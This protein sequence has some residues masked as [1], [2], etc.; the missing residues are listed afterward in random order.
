MDTITTAH[1]LVFDKDKVLLVR[2]GESAG[3]LTGVYGIP[4]GHLQEG[5]SLKEAAIREFHEETGLT[6]DESDVE[7]FPRNTY[8][9]D[10]QRKDGS[11]KHYAMTIFAGVM[12]VGELKA[13]GET[14]PEWIEVDK[15]SNYQLLPNVKEAVRAAQE[16]FDEAYAE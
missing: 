10:I 5:E 15:L 9:A 8:E 14:V 6:V 12:F 1:I 16:F 3:H 4:G 13:T 2:H 7:E 11:T